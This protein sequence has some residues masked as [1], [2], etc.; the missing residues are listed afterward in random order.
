M[1]ARRDY[2][3]VQ[4]ATAIKERLGRNPES[5]QRCLTAVATVVL[6]GGPYTYE[7]KKINP[8]GKSIGAGVW[9]ITH[10]EEVG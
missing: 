8:V 5:E 1:G 9:A 3:V 7:G 4:A 6:L 10:K 2:L